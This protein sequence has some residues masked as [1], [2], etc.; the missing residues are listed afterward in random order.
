VK[1]ELEGAKEAID[2]VANL[3]RK[4]MTTQQNMIDIV[5]IHMDKKSYYHIKMAAWQELHEVLKLK[6]VNDELLEYLASSLRYLLHYS[7]KYNISLPERDKIGEIL[8]RTPIA[9]K[10]PSGVASSPME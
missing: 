7:Q 5:R 9:E 1:K 10:L 4:C 8:D 6:H 3:W 2:G